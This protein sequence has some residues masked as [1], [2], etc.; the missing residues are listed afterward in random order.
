MDDVESLQAEADRI[1][2]LLREAKDREFCSPQNVR[3]SL[4]L[5]GKALGGINKA[6]TLSL[7]DLFSEILKVANQVNQAY[8]DSLWPKGNGC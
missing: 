6:D 8:I 2:S 7:N 4:V 3:N 5:I 1:L